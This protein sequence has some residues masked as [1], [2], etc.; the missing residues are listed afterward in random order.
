MRSTALLMM[1]KNN[2]TET[3]PKR[4][5]WESPLGTHRGY[6]EEPGPR[7]VDPYAKQER[8][9]IQE[10]ERMPLLQDRRVIR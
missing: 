10:V 4:L 9:A 3:E 1:Q 8:D 6:L 5:A 7:F 2:Q